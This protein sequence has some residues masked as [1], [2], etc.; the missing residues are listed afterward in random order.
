P[1][2]GR[3]RVR[4]GQRGA[5]AGAR[6]VHRRVRR[7]TAAW[8][9]ISREVASLARWPV[10]RSVGRSVSRPVGD[11]SVGELSRCPLTECEVITRRLTDSPT[12]RL[13]DRPTD[14]LTDRQDRPHRNQPCDFESHQT[15][16]R[17]AASHSGAGALFVV[18]RASRDAPKDACRSGRV[19]MRWKTFAIGYSLALALLLFAQR[20]PAAHESAQFTAIIDLTHPINPKAPTCEVTDRPQFTA[21]EVA[22]YDREGYFARE[23]CLPE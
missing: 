11:V 13:A 10:S 12:E 2:L 7:A 6:Q 19:R 18:D 20:R 14:R 8:A 22:S 4:A 17:M 15:L 5:H 16:A 21:K 1:A 3:D 23:L 9:G